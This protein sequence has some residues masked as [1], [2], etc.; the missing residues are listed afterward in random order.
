MILEQQAEC[1]TFTCGDAKYEFFPNG[2]IREF[3]VANFM[4]NQFMGHPF[5]GSVNNIFLK[6]HHED[7]EDG[8]YPLLGCRSES[9][10][11]KTSHG[12]VF[13][14]DAEGIHYTVYFTFAR[15][16]LWF[17]KVSLS[18]SGQRVQLIYGQDAGVADKNTIRTNELYMSQYL[19]HFIDEG[20]NGYT[21]CSRQ[22]Q[23]Q[24]GKFPY[25]QQGCVQGRVIGYCTD[26]MQFFGTAVK[27]DQKIKALYDEAPAKKYQYELAYIGLWTEW[28]ILDGPKTAAFYGMFKE[29]LETAAEKALDQDKILAAY[30]G[31]AEAEN[32]EAI[33]PVKKSKSFGGA[34]SSGELTGEELKALFPER[35][36]EEWEDDRLLSF[37]TPEH[38]HVVLQAKEVLTE[39]PHGNIISTLAD[40]KKL[41]R[42]LMTS[43]NYMYGLFHAQISVGNTDANRLLCSNRGLLN[44]QKYTGQ[45]L[46]VKNGDVYQVLAMP[47][48]WAAGFNF[49]TWYYKLGDDILVITAMASADQPQVSLQAYSLKGRSYSFILTSQLSMEGFEFDSPVEISGFESS[50]RIFP[51][52]ASSIRKVYP[53]LSYMI[54]FPEDASVSDDGIFYEDGKGR[55]RTLLCAA[56]SGNEFKVEILGTLDGEYPSHEC[57]AVHGKEGF[58]LELKEELEKYQ[59]FYHQF[60]RGLHLSFA[61]D[62]PAQEKEKTAIEKLNVLSD[63]YIHNA[64]VHFYTPRGLEQ[65]NGAAWGTRDVCQGPMELLLATGHFELAR[66][67][68]LE[69][70]AHQN[71]ETGE[72]PQWFMFDAYPVMAGDCHGDV[73]FWPLKC[74]GDYVEYT[75]DTS[76]FSASV[77]YR[78]PD[79]T[80]G[81]TQTVRGHLE[82]A[83]ESVGG[84]FVDDTALISYAGGDWDDTLQPADPKMKERL[85][86]AWTQALAYQ[87]LE[88]LVKGL[89]RSQDTQDALMANNLKVIAAA[90]KDAF[91]KYLV[92]DGV[93]AGFVYLNDDG[94]LSYMLHPLDDKTGIHYRLLPLTRSII[95]HMAD[96]EQARANVALI[97][98]K[99]TFPDGVRLMDRPARYAGGVSKYFQRA[100][101][102]ANVGREIS[103]QYVHAHIRY[104]EAMAAMGD[105]REAFDS[106]MKIVPVNNKDYVKNA[107]LRQSNAYFSSSEGDF[108]DRYQYAEKFDL[109]K[110]GEMPVKGGWR[111]YSSG[112]GIFMGRLL[113]NIL[114]IRD[115]KTELEIDPV[116]PEKLDGLQVQYEIFDQ[117]VCLCFHIQGDG[118]RVERLVCEDK[119]IPFERM[120]HPYRKGGVRVEKEQWLKAVKNDGN[121]HVYLK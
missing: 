115:K 45:R 121:V 19:D 99:L 5:E 23:S 40:D 69:I 52:S 74:L 61:P 97:R 90:V 106:M 107:K 53:N 118:A 34:F 4:V 110:T 44:L 65:C 58:D 83:L 46:W 81:E 56:F 85:V 57:K 77:P 15:D 21:I 63:W 51:E 76:I 18:G 87:T 98:E 38:T 91:E 104:I 39:R 117:N 84:R 6:V 68:L 43:T 60:K 88:G 93:I 20:P 32:E 24:G 35:I 73:V 55:D 66:E 13:R 75:K 49:S 79:G 29:N 41:S 47:A 78:Y 42:G 89:E 72:W 33:V 82:K 116:I 96:P 109:L 31:L 114:G 70:F 64:F 14:G 119:E 3:T 111:I 25:L 92:K 11:T 113:G 17:W 8:I 26:E 103:L 54:R 80:L 7:G 30:E 37:F 112:P 16:N 94:S 62:A 59:S 105:G 50:V 12:L 102:A 71:G 28:M 86:S 27:K 22:N 67:T 120:D 9:T 1:I 101:Q 36:L 2:D 48:A 95:S 108:S 100:E 10:V